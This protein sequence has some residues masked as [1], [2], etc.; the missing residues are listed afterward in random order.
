MNPLPRS[1]ECFGWDVLYEAPLFLITTWC[2]DSYA[3][4]FELRRFTGTLQ[5]TAP[6]D[7]LEPWIGAP[8]LEHNGGGVVPVTHWERA[9]VELSGYVKFDGCTNFYLQQD[10]ICGVNEYEL[11]AAGL[12]RVYEI[13]AEV[14]D[15][16]CGRT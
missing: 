14:L 1:H 3:L 13:A 12:R 8:M 5:G 7:A 9:E 10:H 6:G 2:R 15:G 4:D 16:W 11:N